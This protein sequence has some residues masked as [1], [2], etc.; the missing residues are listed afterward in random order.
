MNIGPPACSPN[1]AVGGNVICL[2]VA[3]ELVILQNLYLG[4]MSRKSP[5]KVTLVLP[6]KNSAV[7]T[8]P[9]ILTR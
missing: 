2:V 5:D 8:E 9:I 3:P 7:L 4:V 6:P 1:V